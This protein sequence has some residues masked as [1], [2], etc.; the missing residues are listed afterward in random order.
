M[1]PHRALLEAMSSRTLPAPGDVPALEAACIVCGVGS[2]NAPL[3]RWPGW[4][5]LSSTTVNAVAD[6]VLVS[7]AVLVAV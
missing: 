6:A 3:T 2:A 1:A 5:G 4:L 7:F